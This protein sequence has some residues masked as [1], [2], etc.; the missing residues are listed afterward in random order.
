MDFR[1]F[2]EAGTKGEGPNASGARGQSAVAAPKPQAG[3]NPEPGGGKEI[4]GGSFGGGGPT[5]YKPP[6]NSPM[7]TK[8]RAPWEKAKI[9][10]MSPHGA[11]ESPQPMQPV[12]PSTFVSRYMNWQPPSNAVKGSSWPDKSRK[13]ALS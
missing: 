4:P 8:Y 7:A 11:T 10:P 6:G 12:P 5:K 2:L 9:G 3:V 13:K 1:A